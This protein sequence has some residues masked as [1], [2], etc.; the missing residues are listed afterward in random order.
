MV[1]MCGRLAET[2]VRAVWTPPGRSEFP[3]CSVRLRPGSASP[4]SGP[5]HCDP[6]VARPGQTLLTTEASHGVTPKHAPISIPR[7]G[8][9]T[10]S[11]NTILKM[12]P[13]WALQRFDARPPKSTAVEPCGH[14]MNNPPSSKDTDIPRKYGF[15]CKRASF[16][17]S[18]LM[19]LVGR[20]GVK[21]MGN[22]LRPQT[23]QLNETKTRGRARERDP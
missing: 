10:L 9:R 11:S 3:Y 15:S 7:R 23:C 18:P 21:N 5:L 12:R 16:L 20:R 1:R 6:G 22:D 13:P 2:E 14:H 17:A 8:H 4:C 19:I